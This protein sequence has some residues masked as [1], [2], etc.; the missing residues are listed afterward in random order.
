MSSVPHEQPAG[1]LVWFAKASPRR[2]I[3]LRIAVGA[4]GLVFLVLAALVAT[5]YVLASRT[6]DQQLDESVRQAWQRA[7]AAVAG[8]ASDDSEVALLRPDPLT[9]PGL[10]AGT[11]LAV[12][13]A[14]GSTVVAGT[15]GFEENQS[16]TDADIEDMRLQAQNP[17]AGRVVRMKLAGED[18]ALVAQPVKGPPGFYG[19]EQVLV[20][21]LPADAYDATNR[22]LLWVLVAGSA[23]ALVLVG[24]GVWW[25]I[26]RSLRPLEQ[27]AVAARDVSAAPLSSGTL[28]LSEDRLPDEL[29]GREDEVGDVALAL[30][31]LIDS[32]GDALEARAKSENQLRKFV[33][34]AS[35]ELRTPLAANREAA[36]S[37]EVLEGMGHLRSEVDLGEIVLEAA[38]DA[39]LTNPDHEWHTSIPDEP[40]VVRASRSQMNHLVQNLLSNAQKHTPSGTRVNTAL[41][42][43]EGFAVLTV[44]DN[45]PGIPPELGQS[46]FDRFI[47]GDSARASAQGSTGLGLS[48]VQSVARAHGGEARVESGA[49]WTTFIV[50]LPL[51]Q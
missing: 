45:G 35:H 48:I 11:V 3:A 18:Y 9:A 21:G 34:D 31:E 47:R 30:N 2:S 10:P 44:A 27:V 50:T 5:T 20:L 13:S 28:D 46:V 26:R 36:A 32:V 8:P 15:V 25:W 49:G 6:V 29:S 14:D 12:V 41:Y 7:A 23:I 19:A 16:L 51:A 1:S 17:E 22:Q 40:A 37:Q 43:D 4:V 42:I 38:T 24:A 39:A 33:A